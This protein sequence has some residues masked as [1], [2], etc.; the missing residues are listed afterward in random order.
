MEKTGRPVI[1]RRRFMR[2]CTSW[3]LRRQRFDPAGFPASDARFLSKRYG[4]PAFEYF[5][6]ELVPKPGLPGP[7]EWPPHGL[8][9][10]RV[11]QFFTG[12][13]RHGH[14]AE[15]TV[16]EG[17]SPNRPRQDSRAHAPTASW[18]PHAHGRPIHR[19][20]SPVDVAPHRRKAKKG[21]RNPPG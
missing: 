7:S 16:R 9:R 21:A 8:I 12:R 20:V 5:G 17:P 15:R 1:G 10:R 4:L 14:E 13:L 11:V 18:P 6:L 3:T 19:R 2:V